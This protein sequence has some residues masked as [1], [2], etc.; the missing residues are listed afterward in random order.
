MAPSFLVMAATAAVILL[1]L[2]LCRVNQLWMS[3]PQE[4]LEYSPHR[5]TDDEIKE[6]YE[7]V[8]KEPID[9]RK[10]LPQKLERRYM[11]VGG[12]GESW[13]EK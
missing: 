1:S 5:W 2:Y 8:C 4:A 6:T 11:V 13:P 3:V 10:V 9:F 12:S 7:R